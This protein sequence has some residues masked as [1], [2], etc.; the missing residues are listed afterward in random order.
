MAKLAVYQLFGLKQAETAKLAVSA[1][2]LIKI[3]ML[4]PNYPMPSAGMA[5]S[6]NYGNKVLTFQYYNLIVLPLF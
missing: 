3:N 1:L 5:S 4:S 2:I 6:Q